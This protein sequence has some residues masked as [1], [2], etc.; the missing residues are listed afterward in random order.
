MHCKPGKGGCSIYDT[1][2]ELC[3]RFMCFWLA[4]DYL[5]EKWKPTTA[6]LLVYLGDNT[7]R[8]AIHVDPAFPNNWRREPYYSQIRAWGVSCADIQCQVVVYIKDRAIAILPDKEVDL[9]HV[10]ARDHIIFGR[11][12][13]EWRASVKREHEVPLEDRGKRIVR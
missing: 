8:V 7:H 5:D 9:G 1:R 12:D 10:G 4:L 11:L 6:K 13:G 2:P 3:R